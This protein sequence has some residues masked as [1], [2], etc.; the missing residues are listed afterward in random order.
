[1]VSE[2]HAGPRKALTSE[3]VGGRRWNSCSRL[4]VQL[5]QRGSFGWEAP[6]HPLVCRLIAFAPG[7]DL[8]LLPNK[9]PTRPS[10]TLHSPIGALYSPAPV[11]LVFSSL[12]LINLHPLLR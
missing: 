4:P 11:C 5:V 6:A 12:Y 8:Y 10:H 1:V 2:L 7:V 3:P 9:V